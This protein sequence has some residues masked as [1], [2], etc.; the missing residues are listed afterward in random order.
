MILASSMDTT[1]VKYLHRGSRYSFVSSHQW[2][3]RYGIW[4]LPSHPCLQFRHWWS[5]KAL[6]PYRLRQVNRDQHPVH[7][8]SGSQASIE[9]WDQWKDLI[10]SQT[11]FAWC[12]TSK[13]HSKITSRIISMTRTS[14]HALQYPGWP[15]KG[16]TRIQTTLSIFHI[17]STPGMLRGMVWTRSLAQFLFPVMIQ[18]FKG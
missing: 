10:V 13:M 15:K 7:R 2:C 16:K 3:F 5:Q 9:G 6:C 8:W 4:A 18:P 11:R 12:W 1:A 17:Q 14:H